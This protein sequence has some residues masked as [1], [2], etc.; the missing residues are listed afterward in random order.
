MPRI[1]IN[2]TDFDL[3]EVLAGISQLDTE[4]LR[5]VM[6]EVSTFIARKKASSLSAEETELML[7]INE[8]LPPETQQRYTVLQQK[9]VD[10]NITE[11]EQ[12]ELLQ[13]TALAEE[14]AVERLTYLVEL[15]RLWDVSVD[16]TMKRL[17]IK[18]P[19]SI[20]A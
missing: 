6:R 3:N 15:S 1:K 18:T 14:K 2:A 17:D 10:E 13:L 19:P 4:E 11:A 12:E 20:H 7:K 9:L 16:E 5:Q 8:G